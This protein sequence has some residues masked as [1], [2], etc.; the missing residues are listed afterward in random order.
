MPLT[1]KAIYRDFVNGDLDK[2]FAIELLLTPIDNA[3]NIETR[4]ESITVL[5]EIQVDDGVNHRHHAAGGL[6]VRGR[7][8]AN[9]THRGCSNRSAG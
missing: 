2:S 4:I 5:N 9:A 1:P 6:F 3:E 8:D 7:F